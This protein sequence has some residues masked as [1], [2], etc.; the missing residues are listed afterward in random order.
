MIQNMLGLISRKP[1]VFLSRCKNIKN[2]IANK[3]AQIMFWRQKAVSITATLSPDGGAGGSGPKQSI[4]E[5]AV[6][7]IEE[8]ER[9]IKAD[10]AKLI[11]IENETEY[12]ISYL[13]TDSRYR[14]VLRCLYLLGFSRE[15]T[16][17]RMNYDK[18][19]VSRLHGKALDHMARNAATY[20]NESE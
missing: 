3:E 2:D 14:D 12:A 4:V 20:R 19:W 18:D 1:E 5:N 17:K 7:E 16:A 6:C 9:A 15:Q 8:H 13:V 10:I 11:Q